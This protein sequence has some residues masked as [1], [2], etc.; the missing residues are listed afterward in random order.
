M[1]AETYSIPAASEKKSTKS[2]SS[3]CERKTQKKAS[4]KGEER[5]Y[6]LSKAKR[7]DGFPAQ[8]AVEDIAR[9]STHGGGGSGGG[10]AEHIYLFRNSCEE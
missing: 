2:L 3:E 1:D 4:T 10:G 6:R 8:V 9:A 7:R 5:A